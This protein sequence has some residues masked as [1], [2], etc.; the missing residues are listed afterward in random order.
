MPVSSLNKKYDWLSVLACQR[1]M[2]SSLL[3]CNIPGGGGRP[4]HRACYAWQHDWQ[5]GDAARWWCHPRGERPRGGQRPHGVTAHA[6]GLQWKHHTQNPAQLQG[7]TSTCTGQR[8]ADSQQVQCNSIIYKIFKNILPPS[9]LVEAKLIKINV[10][11]T[12]THFLQQDVYWCT[13][14]SSSELLV[15]S[16]NNQMLRVQSSLFP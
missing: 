12:W 1:F 13:R 15:F 9:C 16:P 14:S 11:W 5:A 6:E 10:K 3:G 4:C 8:T 7:H 2:V